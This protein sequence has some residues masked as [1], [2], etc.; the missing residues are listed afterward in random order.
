MSSPVAIRFDYSVFGINALREFVK[1]D[2]C[3]LGNTSKARTPNAVGFAEILLLEGDGE[4][5]K[6]WVVSEGCW[7]IKHV[8][9]E[10]TYFSIMTDA[11]FRE[12]YG[13]PL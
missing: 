4:Y 10:C 2:I 8:D 3:K 13:V 12:H 11:A 7:V 6:A 5:R 1:S 9:H